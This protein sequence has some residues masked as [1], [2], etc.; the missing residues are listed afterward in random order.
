MTCAIA[1]GGQARL[2]AAKKLSCGE[3]KMSEPQAERN[4]KATTKGAADGLGAHASEWSVLPCFS[5][6]PST[7]WQN[8]TI[9][10]QSEERHT[11][12]HTH[13]THTRARLLVLIRSNQ[14]LALIIAM[15]ASP[16]YTSLI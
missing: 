15:T 10:L 8:G 16:S 6:P 14:L 5:A 7:N 2:L 12:T 9:P 3:K 13:T 1:C 4:D 11:Q